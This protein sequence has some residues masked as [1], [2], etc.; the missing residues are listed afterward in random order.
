LQRLIASG[1]LRPTD[2]ARRELLRSPSLAAAGGPRDQ[3]RIVRSAELLGN[4]ERKLRMAL[5][6]AER[7]F[8]D[9]AAPVLTECLQIAAKA[10]AMMTDG[11]PPDETAADEKPQSAAA[12]PESTSPEVQPKPLVSVTGSM[13]RV[14]AELR[15]SLQALAAAA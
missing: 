13:E 4:A 9:E 10:R 14:L 11:M 2:G 12:S 15:G 8:A 5:L 6:L 3:A 7:G 1:L